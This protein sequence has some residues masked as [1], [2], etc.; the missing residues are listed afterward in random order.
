MK[1]GESGLLEIAPVAQET[2]PELPADLAEAL[3]S[4]PDVR[5]VWDETTTIARV[6]WIHWVT[7]AKQVKT[8]TKRVKDACEMLT[9][10][11]KCVCCFDPSG[12]DSQA[13]SAPDAEGGL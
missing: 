3:E 9:D 8:R 13:F 10:G 4:R 12:Y 6:N 5:R 7:S 11:K 2:E 1:V